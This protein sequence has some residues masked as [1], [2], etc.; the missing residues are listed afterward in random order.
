MK[1]AAEINRSYYDAQSAGREDYWRHMA[2]PRFRVRRI[3]SIIAGYNSSDS[4]VD[5]GC[6]N[7]ALLE[8]I[9]ARLPEARLAG[10]DLSSEQLRQNKERL[11]NIDWY[12]ADLQ[13]QPSF[14]A[15]TFNVVVASEVIE[16]LD[17]PLAL[18]RHAFA[19]A[20]A[21][22]MLIVTTQSGPV[23]ATERSVGHQRHFT[24]DELTALLRDAGWTPVRVW[25]EGF[26]FHNLS[27]WWANRDAEASMERFGGKPYGVRERFICALLRGAFYLNSRQRGAQLFAVGRRDS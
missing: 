18:L 24:A 17:K 16:H 15:S 27:K 20:A 3:L 25:N 5:L 12:C 1:S 26:P 22:A 4:V 13:E 14:A 19:L 11:P 8:E 21:D 2:A 6:G 9:A 7:G 23:G 10:V